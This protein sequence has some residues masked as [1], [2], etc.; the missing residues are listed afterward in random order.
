MFFAEPTPGTENAAEEFTGISTNEVI[1]SHD[2]GEFNG[3]SIRLSGASQGEEIRYTLDATVPNA[4]SPLY[5]SAINIAEDT[6]V[7][8]RIFQDNFIPSRTSSRTF[9]TSNTLSV[10][11]SVRCV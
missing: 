9:I 1:F 8:A 7:R 3:Q 4:L 6:V 2:G 11:G 10:V 5:S